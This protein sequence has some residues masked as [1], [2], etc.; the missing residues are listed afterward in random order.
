[1]VCRRMMERRPQ[2]VRGYIYNSQF[3]NDVKTKYHRVYEIRQ[4]PQIVPDK[5]TLSL[6]NSN[7]LIFGALVHDRLSAVY[8]YP[9]HSP[10]ATVLFSAG[11]WAAFD[12]AA[13]ATRVRS[14]RW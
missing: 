1:M 4:I 9:G 5:I 7:V 14:G 10:S 3:G 13:P 8:D 12:L 6:A 2:S 11:M